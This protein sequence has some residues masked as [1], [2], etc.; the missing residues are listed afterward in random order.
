[1]PRNKLSRQSAADPTLIGT[2]EEVRGP[3]AWIR[4][5]SNL[6]SG[7]SIVDGISYR[8][9]QVGSF[10][11]IPQG[12]H[13]LYGVVSSIGAKPIAGADVSDVDRWLT[14]ELVGEAISHEFQRGVSRH[15]NV[16]DFVH[17]VTQEELALLYR[18]EGKQDVAVGALASAEHIAVRVSADQILNRHAAIL[19]STGAG[20]STTVASLL[21]SIVHSSGDDGA[22]YPASR[23]MLF[24]VHGEYSQAFRDIA[25]V[26][27][28]SPR[29]NEN[30]LVIPFWALDV[31]ELLNFL[32]GSLSEEHEAVILD[33]IQEYK[34]EYLQVNQ[35][36]G[37]EPE[38]VTAETPIPFSLHRLWYELI[39]YEL[40]TLT[41]E[42]RDEPALE[43]QGDPLALIPPVY[44]QHALGA[45]GPW[46]NPNPRG[47][48]RQLGLLRSRLL[49][50]RFDFLLHPPGYEP[51]ISGA[52]EQDLDTLLNDWL[53]LE[54]SITILDLSGVPN[55][56]LE[57]LIG[58]V[59]RIVYESLYWSREK[60][61]GGVERPLLI[62]LEEAHRYLSDL[63][64]SASLMVQRI[65]KEGRKYGVGSVIVSQR[66]S[67]VNETVLSQC[68][69]FFAMRLSN[70][71][72]R[73]KGK[74]TLP[75]NLA[76]LM[77]MLPV[78]R[79]GECVIV[80]EACKL[81]VRC[82]ISLPAEEH[83]PASVDP[84]VTEGWG[85]PR[86]DE[87]YDRVLL[88]WRTQNPRAVVDNVDIERQPVED[89]G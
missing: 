30:A 24:D 36:E 79:T 62:V 16:D 64:G 5:S 2:V 54:Q 13:N 72:D 25:S 59:L 75:D 49:D 42:N 26:F 74:G 39:D 63:D 78:L 18:T 70:P 45:A 65:V 19:G 23:I 6:S 40:M 11:R 34:R 53:G 52:V 41:G 89:E 27:S 8:I 55:S 44:A 32:L 10:V 15:P 14:V 29:E 85:V 37:L 46:L 28:A 57:R 76:S 61:E 67:E 60:S 31:R 73:A 88:S 68:G 56:V 82:R 20:K 69:T 80:G 77:E 66:P 17:L 43:Q 9:G 21:R 38:Q 83:R 48:K 71:A 86:A 87:G 84:S 33:K 58:S 7:V 35:I 81:P 1:M 4:L 51:E 22:A 50:R 3:T 47:I 12:Y